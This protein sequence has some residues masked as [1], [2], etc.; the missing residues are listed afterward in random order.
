MPLMSGRPL[1]RTAMA[2]DFDLERTDD[3]ADEPDLGHGATGRH[4]RRRHRQECVAGTHRVD[5]IL[6]ERRDRMD[7]FATS[8][9]STQ[10]CLPCVMIIFEQST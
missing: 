5:D 1:D 4:Q 7:D 6:G 3:I 9:K 8:R 2:D 10:P